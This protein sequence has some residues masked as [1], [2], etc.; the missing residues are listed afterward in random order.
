MSPISDLGRNPLFV[1]RERELAA[2]PIV[3]DKLEDIE[4]PY[5]RR[6]RRILF[7]WTCVLSYF[8]VWF[9]D[10]QVPPALMGLFGIFFMAFLI[11][12]IRKDIHIVFYIFSIKFFKR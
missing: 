1:Q 12:E 2:N 7:A 8:I 6:I 10:P 11:K 9:K 3:A 4:K 5:D